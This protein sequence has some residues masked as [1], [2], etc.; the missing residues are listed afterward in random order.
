MKEVTYL[1]ERFPVLGVCENEIR[2]AIAVLID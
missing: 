1:L 2:E